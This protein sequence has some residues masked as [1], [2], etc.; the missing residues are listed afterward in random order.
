M[1][2]RLASKLFARRNAMVYSRT[3][4]PAQTDHAPAGYTFVDLMARDFRNCELA[5]HRGRL[6]RFEQRL[7]DGY[8]CA[9]FRDADGHVVSYIWI[10]LGD[11]GPSSVAIWR[12]V[13]VSLR[14]K[15]AF[16]W[17]CRTD[18]LHEGR[19]LYRTGLRMAGTRLAQG[20]SRR[21]FIETE[22]DNAASRR[23]IEG[24]GFLPATELT[25]VATAGVY[26]MRTAT[27]GLRRVRAPLCLGEEIA[28]ISSSS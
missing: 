10:A 27:D 6:P 17:D 25:L 8:R 5:R 16:F 4:D 22:P 20:G 12:D 18:P 7:M 21:A 19:G 9:G 26:W 13:K 24:A 28:A 23:G 2:R 11:S 14:D 15:D 3:L 1:I